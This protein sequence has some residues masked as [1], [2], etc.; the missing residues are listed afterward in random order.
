VRPEPAP[1][2]LLCKIRKELLEVLPGVRDRA[3]EVLPTT[4]IETLA[5]WPTAFLMFSSSGALIFSNFA[6][7]T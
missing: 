3:V 6:A 1:Y 4:T 2:P 7:R 5:A